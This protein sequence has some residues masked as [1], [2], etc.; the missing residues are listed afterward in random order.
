MGGQLVDTGGQQCNLHFW[1]T[2]VTG[3][4][5]VVFNDSG[6]DAGSDHFYFL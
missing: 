2:G 1:A 5:C 6:F 3:L 4:A